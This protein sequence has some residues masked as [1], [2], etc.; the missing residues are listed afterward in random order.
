MTSA[1]FRFALP[2][3]ALVRRRDFASSRFWVAQ[4]VAWAA[5]GFALMVPW[6]GRYPVSVMWA[7]KV[8]VG[9]T[10]LLVSSALRFL[11]LAVMRRNGG[12]FPLFASVA[13][14]SLVGGLAWSIAMALLLGGQAGDQLVQLGSLS[15]GVPALSG[16]LYHALVMAVWSL[17]YVSVVALRRQAPR[18]ARNGAIQPAAIPTSDLVVRD[19]RKSVMLSVKEIDWVQAEG[20]YVRVHL[21]AR[22]LLL[23]DTMSRIDSGLAPGLLRIHRSTIVNVSRVSET[24]ALPNRELEVVLRNGVRLRASRT[25]ADRLRSALGMDGA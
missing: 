5:Y 17:A 19:G 15:A 1:S 8:I 7:N 6:L 21:G 12:A 18:P 3:S 13:V 10:G 9:G 16:V 22:S 2:P 23:R 11:Y 20:D 24:H 14:G 4:V 25:Y